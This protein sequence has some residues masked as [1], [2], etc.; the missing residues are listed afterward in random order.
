MKNIDEFVQETLNG[1]AL[2]LQMY[3]QAQDR[4]KLERVRLTRVESSH[5]DLEV[6]REGRRKEMERENLDKAR[7]MADQVVKDLARQRKEEERREEIREM[8]EAKRKEEE[9]RAA[10]A[11][12]MEE[13]IRVKEEEEQRA[14]AK[15]I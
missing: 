2:E 12:E 4:E 10:R 9:S 5:A 1:V 13:L 15:V 8:I 7:Q 14:L 3:T 11:K 6:W